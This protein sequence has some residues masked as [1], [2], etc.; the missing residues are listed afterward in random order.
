MNF[1]ML[2][3]NS[4]QKEYFLGDN[5]ISESY[6]KIQPFIQRN[7][8]FDLNIDVMFLQAIIQ[9]KFWPR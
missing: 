9:I 8:T 4:I 7:E 1:K 2:I 5:D 3:Q 6:M